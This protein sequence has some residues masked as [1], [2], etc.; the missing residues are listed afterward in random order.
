MNV[1]SIQFRLVLWYTVL[2]VFVSVGFAIYTYFNLR[3]YLYNEMGERLAHRA[4]NIVAGIVNNPK[5]TLPDIVE[6]IEYI[7]SPAENDRFIRIL[8]G[9]SIIY[10][11][12]QPI[13]NAFV[14]ADIPVSEIPDGISHESLKTAGGKDLFRVLVPAQIMGKPGLVEMAAPSGD[15]TEPIGGLLLDLSG[16][17]PFVIL[18]MMAGGVWLV[19]R[20]FFPIEKMR[21]TAADI[22]FGNLSNRLPVP[23]T[24]DAVESLSRTLNQM[25]ER[26]DVAYQQASR[27]SADASHELRTPLT[28]MRAEL[29]TLIDASPL[30]DPV[31]SRIGSILQ[32]TERLSRVTENLFAISRLEAGEAKISQYAVELGDI[33]ESTVEQMMLLAEEKGHIIRLDISRPVKIMADSTRISQVVVN[34]LDNAIK[35]TPANGSIIVSVN[36]V[37]GMAMLEVSDNG[38]GIPAQF[39]PKVLDRF[40]RVESAAKVERGGAG[41]GLSIVRSICQAHA[42]SIDIAS[43]EAKGTRVRVVLPLAKS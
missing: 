37:A 18:V 13:S 38:I 17:L 15:V 41:L 36:A 42:G 30:A 20:A 34:L 23:A 10:Q 3:S 1:R 4:E 39:L 29:E 27:F 26:L 28:I 31:R 22:T 5:N 16:G 19:R 40:Y 8:Q 21:S 32:E 24:G 11:S 14:T 12:A 33:V 43:E 6:K 25:L 35:Y 9:H 2:T 7:Y